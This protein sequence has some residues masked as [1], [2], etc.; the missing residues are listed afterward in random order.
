MTFDADSLDNA[1]LPPRDK[2]IDRIA[3]ETSPG[4]VLVHCQAGMSRSATVVAAFLMQVLE[5]GPV[6]A[7]EMIREKR[8]VVE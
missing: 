6:E 3:G 7:V 2:A 8:P 4:G 1:T 5:L